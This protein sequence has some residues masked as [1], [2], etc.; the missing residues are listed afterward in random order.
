ML[1]TELAQHHHAIIEHIN[2]SIEEQLQLNAIGI[3]P[4]ARIQ[5]IAQSYGT[6]PILVCTAQDSR[7]AI[8]Y[9]LAAKIKVSLPIQEL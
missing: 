9:D 3:C 5:K 1:L 2:A 7:F 6:Q 8:G 4:Q